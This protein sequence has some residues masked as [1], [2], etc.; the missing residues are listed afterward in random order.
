MDPLVLSALIAGTVSFCGAVLTLIAARGEANIK[1]K[2]IEY[3]AK[4]MAADLE[5]LRQ[6]HLHEITKRRIDA[7]PHLWKVLLTYNFNWKV[8]GRL[9]NAEWAQEH[10]QA[11]NQVNADIGL[12]FSQRVYEQ[13]NL[14]RARLIQIDRDFSEGRHVNESAF[15]ALEE[16]ITGRNGQPGLASY[17]KDDLG[18][19]RDALLSIGAARSGSDTI[20]MAQ[21]N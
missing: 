19:Y 11:L 13:F 15:D 6:S 4:R 3:V 2:E 5:A 16:I 20:S 17:L 12:F 7:Y 14:Y 9:R 8:V 18:S 21:P 1:S 10:L